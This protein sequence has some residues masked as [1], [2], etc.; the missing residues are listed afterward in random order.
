MQGSLGCRTDYYVFLEKACIPTSSTRK[1]SI[2]ATVNPVDE[3]YV[4]NKQV[5]E[6]CITYLRRE[7][8]TVNKSVEILVS[9]NFRRLKF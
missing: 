8:V 9:W 6:C 3:L 5:A 2:K 1:L 4:H 7:Y